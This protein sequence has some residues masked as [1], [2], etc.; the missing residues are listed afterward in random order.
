MGSILFVL[1]EVLRISGVYTEFIFFEKTS[2]AALYMYIINTAS[3]GFTGLIGRI[4]ELKVLTYI[5]KISYGIY[6]YH[7]LVPSLICGCLKLLNIN[8][9]TEIVFN[10]IIN[11]VVTIICATISWYIIEKP[12]NRLK[13]IN[14]SR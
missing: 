8:R 4:L 6:L 13:D 10:F 5:G 2:D 7:N 9:P 12:I 3:S 1:L 14:Q 11:S